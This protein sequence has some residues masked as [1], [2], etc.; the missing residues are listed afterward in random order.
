M[1]KILIITGELSGDIHASEFIRE[2]IAARPEIR[3]FAVGG[4]NMETAGAQIILSY[5]SLTAMGFVSPL[6]NIFHYRRILGKIHRWMKEEK[7]DAVVLVDFPG[8]NLQ[9]AMFAH[10]LNIPVVYYILPQVW[11][12]GT[13]RIRQIKK[14]VDLALVILPFVPKFFSQYGVRSIYVGHPV[15][16]TVTKRGKSMPDNADENPFAIG[17]FPGSRKSE[18]KRH[19]CVMFDTA[20]IIQKRHPQV[21]FLVACDKSPAEKTV[22]PEGTTFIPQN[23]YEIMRRSRVLIAASGTVTLEGAFFEKP[24]V[25]IY[26]TEPMTYFLAK[27]LAKVPYISLVNITGRERILPEF[28]QKNAI[29][30]KIA[31]CS[32]KLLFDEEARRDMVEKLQKVKKKLGAPGASKR[33]A[34]CFIRFLDEVKR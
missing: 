26:K 3:F 17:L 8:F 24:M 7:P 25:V 32:E 20:R 12:W 19:L 14:Y 31:E 2:T 18:I 9:V 1:Q 5:E 15:L 29:P 4:K 21:K 30:E 33:A 13:W 16:D 34:G 28:I 23:P 10:Q 22:F 6:L 27:I 11:A